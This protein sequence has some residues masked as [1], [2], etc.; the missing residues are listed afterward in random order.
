MKNRRLYKYSV[1][2]QQN[3]VQKQEGGRIYNSL[4]NWLLLKQTKNQE[5]KGHRPLFLFFKQQIMTREMKTMTTAMTDTIT[6]VA[7][8]VSGV[9]L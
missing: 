1:T 3:V 6:I 4:I 7:R 8:R 2:L 9:T 5:V